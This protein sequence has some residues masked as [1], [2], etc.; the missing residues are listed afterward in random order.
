LIS[1]KDY[2]DMGDFLNLYGMWW[3]HGL[4][5][6]RKD[7]SANRYSHRLPP[8]VS[9]RVITSPLSRSTCGDT[10]RAHLKRN[11]TTSTPSFHSASDC[12]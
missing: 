5:P 12:S 4:C 9:S 11:D 10:T 3:G 8:I 1:V 7:G 2:V 6:A